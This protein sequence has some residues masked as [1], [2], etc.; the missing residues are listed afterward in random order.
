MNT[1][2]IRNKTIFT[3]IKISMNNSIFKVYTDGACTNNGYPNAKCA[4]G[5]HFPEN[6]FKQIP[7]VYFIFTYQCN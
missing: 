7:D 3:T 6:N 5:I 1:L 2:I 4:I